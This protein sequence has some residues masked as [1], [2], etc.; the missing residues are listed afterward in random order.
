MFSPRAAAVTRSG[1]D[2]TAASLPERLFGFLFVVRGLPLG[3][4]GRVRAVGLKAASRGGDDEEAPGR[5]PELGE[6]SHTPFLSPFEVAAR[7][8]CARFAKPR[9]GEYL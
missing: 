1:L 9:Q 6:A 8:E 7:A 3:E 4:I 2:T 5:A